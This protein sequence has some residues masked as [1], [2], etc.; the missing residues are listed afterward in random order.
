[1]KLFLTGGTGF[2]GSELVER[3]APHFEKIYL[4]CRRPSKRMELVYEKFSNIELVKG[5]ISGPDIVED[6]AVLK[7]IKDE[8]DV[9]FHG[10][11]YYDIEGPYSSCF[12]YNV[13]GTQNILFLANHCK[14]LV[15]FH[16]ISTIAV[17]GNY[18]GVF[19]EDSL[20]EGQKFSNHYAK[21]KYDAEAMVRSFEFKGS[22]HIYRL[23]ILIGNSKTGRMPKIDGP[24]YFFKF[25]SK[26]TDKFKKLN[27]IKFL[28]LPFDEKAIMPFIPVDEAALILEMALSSPKKKKL[29][30]YHVIGQAPPSVQQFVEDTLSAFNIKLKVMPLPY[31]PLYKLVLPKIGLP[32]ELL[33][34]MYGKCQYE[35][36]HL[37][38]DFQA[39]TRLSYRDYSGPFYQYAK[40]MF[41]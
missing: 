35:T 15:H 24:Y 30:C 27:K 37:M 39:I 36:S 34:Y 13:V 2:L 14:K 26:V 20:N 23:G 11:A 41:K 8:V 6:A 21:T 33:L 19:S 17:A 29:N 32:S 40:G 18:S 31:S 7:K 1:M 22:K 16:Y 9:I 12:M 10:A 28:P 4:L 3:L 5:D 25:L 38:N